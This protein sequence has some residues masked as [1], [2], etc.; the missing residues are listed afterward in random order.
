MHIKD[1][2][3]FE[4]LKVDIFILSQENTEYEYMAFS[5]CIKLQY[6]GCV[7]SVVSIIEMQ[8]KTYL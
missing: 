3:N 6:Y 2:T 5:C 1:T 7:T 8:S 4:A